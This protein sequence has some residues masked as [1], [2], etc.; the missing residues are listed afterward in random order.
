MLLIGQ[1]EGGGKWPT[2]IEAAKKVKTALLLRTANLLRN[3]FEVRSILS[4][5][6]I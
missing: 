2:E 6:Y 4:I 1:V 5:S 3:Q